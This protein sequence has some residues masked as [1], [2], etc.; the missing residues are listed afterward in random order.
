[1]GEFGLGLRALHL[2]FFFLFGIVMVAMGVVLF[3]HS[4][5]NP[6]TEFLLAVSGLGAFLGFLCTTIARALL[7]KNT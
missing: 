3:S 6:I 5:L 4:D 2:M 7:Q 1:M